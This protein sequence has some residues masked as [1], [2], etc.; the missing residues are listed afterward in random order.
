MLLAVLSP[1]LCPYSYLSFD[2]KHLK[3]IIHVYKSQFSSSMVLQT[4]FNTTVALH[5]LR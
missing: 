4:H 3:R 1:Q 5:S 2:N